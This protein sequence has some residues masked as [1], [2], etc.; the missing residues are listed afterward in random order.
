M[1][2]SRGYARGYAMADNIAEAYNKKKLA[3]TED[4]SEAEKARLARA[5]GMQ[6]VPT[7]GQMEMADRGMG[8]PKTL[9]QN[10]FQMDTQIQPVGMQRM[11]SVSP[12][13]DAA[14]Q[15]MYGNNPDIYQ[16]LGIQRVP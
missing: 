2:M 1:S 15:Q 16:Y 6:P 10:T 9:A 7:G 14:I 8:L 13:L 4:E 12:A 3:E 5:G 11:P